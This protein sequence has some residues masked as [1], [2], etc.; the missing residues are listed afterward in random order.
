MSRA[1]IAKSVAVAIVVLS[2]LTAVAGAGAAAWQGPLQISDAGLNVGDTTPHIALGA[3]G[4]AGAAWWDEGSGG[5]FVLARKR[6]GAAWSAPVTIAAGGT[7]TPIFV[8]VDG[9]GDITAAYATTGPVWNIA[10]WGGDLPAPMTAPL[11]IVNPL[12][13]TDLAMNS[14][15]DAVISGLSGVAAAVGVT[16]A[17]CQGFGGFFAIHPYD[18]PVNGF[19]ANSARVAINAS[20]MAVVLIRSGA[21]LV[22]ATRTTSAD[23]PLAVET[24]HSTT[25]VVTNSDTPSVAIDA[26]GNVFAAF[27]HT[28]GRPAQPPAYLAAPAGRGWQESPDLSSTTTGFAASNVN[29]VVNSSG[30]ALLVW[31]E[32]GPS[33]FGN[34]QARAGSTGT[35]IWG[36]IETVNDAGADVPVAAIGNDGTAVAAWERQTV[37]GNIRQA[38]VRSP[39]ASGT[40]SDIHNLSS[41]H[42]NY[43]QPSISTDGRRRLRDDQR[44]L[45][46]HP[47]LQAGAHLGL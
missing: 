44:A 7:Q 4:D 23:W 32:M 27:V 2:F 46:G 35:G 11:A 15:G 39:G 26:A 5:R 16:L 6:A 33:S 3:N 41:L 12:N 22:A 37:S 34:I 24:V 30:A 43:T 18:Y 29:V 47:R 25:D 28:S 17:Y 9:R 21:T 20:G 36:P 19:A 8:G 38:R 1:R 10:A 42:A 40:W 45:L 13:I 31:E 14:N